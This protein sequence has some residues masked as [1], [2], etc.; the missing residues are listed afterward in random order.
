MPWTLKAK[1][2]LRLDY[3]VGWEMGGESGP[4]LVSRDL[5]QSR[6]IH[7]FHYGDADFQMPPKSK[8]PL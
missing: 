1:G 8:L 5:A 2:G 4:A 6:V 3:R 7:A